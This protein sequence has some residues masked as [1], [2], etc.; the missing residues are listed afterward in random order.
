MIEALLGKLIIPLVGLLAVSGA[1]ILVL[2]VEYMREGRAAAPM[3]PVKAAPPP[4]PAPR[5]TLDPELNKSQDTVPV[6]QR[7]ARDSREMQAVKPPV[8]TPPPPRPERNEVL[9]TTNIMEPATIPVQNTRRAEGKPAAVGSNIVVS[10]PTAPDDLVQLPGKLEVIYGNFSPN[11]PREILFFRPPEHDGPPCYKFSKTPGEGVFHVQMNHYTVTP[12][13][14]AEL[15]FAE[16]RHVLV[17]TVP[18]EDMD[19]Y[20]TRINGI[21]MAV[22]ERHNLAAGDI[23]SMGIFRLKLTL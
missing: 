15:E 8:P 4:S 10:L 22:G 6:R 16:G 5:R 12:L 3:P 18:E 13:V 2:I 9:F 1:G 11:D 17:N 20:Q 23:I 7:G 14:Q 19:R 21:P